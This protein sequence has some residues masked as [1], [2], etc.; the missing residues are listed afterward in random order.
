[1]VEN[2]GALETALGVLAAIWALNIGKS[3][4]TDLEKL[5]AGLQKVNMGVEGLTAGATGVT[6]V[7]GK[8]SALLA[9]FLAGYDP[10]TWL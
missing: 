10:G 8:L 9:S 7:I 6:A 4:V 2:I 5:A 1:M 3:F